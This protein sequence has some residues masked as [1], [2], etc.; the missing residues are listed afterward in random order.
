MN[1]ILTSTLFMP[2]QIQT[3]E[4]TT[5]FTMITSVILIITILV[6]VF[7]GV[8]ILESVNR[9]NDNLSDSNKHFITKGVFIF[10]IL[11]FL[12]P[13]ARKL[14]SNG[15]VFFI[16]LIVTKILFGVHLSIKSREQ[17][18]NGI[19]WFILGFVEQTSALIA[20]GLIPKLL[21]NHL[22]LRIK[23]DLMMNF[24]SRFLNSRN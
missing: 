15:L 3:I 16:L 17:G 1:T 20:L 2:A 8:A 23:K 19:I 18:R 11:C 21:K 12:T 4:E 6:F 9:I 5:S 14:I 22:I 7:K 10:L 24:L 13:L